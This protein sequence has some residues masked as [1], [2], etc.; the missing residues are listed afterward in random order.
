MKS[1]HRGVWSGGISSRP[2]AVTTMLS[3]VIH[4]TQS[5][6]GETCYSRHLQTGWSE[7]PERINSQDRCDQNVTAGLRTLPDI[8]S[9][10]VLPR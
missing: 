8:P 4:F 10:L 1:A 9:P 2:A 7:D 3:N 6:Q 5:N